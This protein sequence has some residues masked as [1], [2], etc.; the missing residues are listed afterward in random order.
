NAP[1]SS[2]YLGRPWRPYGKAVFINCDLPSLIKA[3]GWNNWGKESNEST[4]YYAEYK[5]RGKGFQPQKRVAWSYQLEE[6]DLAAYSL[7]QIFKG[8]DPQ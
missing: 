6:K 4:A 5:N 2:F 3:E 8:W 7:T 1:E